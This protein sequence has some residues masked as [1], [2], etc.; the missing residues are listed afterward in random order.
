DAAPAGGLPGKP[1][2]L[3]DIGSILFAAKQR[4]AAKP[5]AAIP[6]PTS[7]PTPGPRVAGPVPPTQSPL[8]LAPPPRNWQSNWGKRFPSPPPSPRSDDMQDL[9]TAMRNPSG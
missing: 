2:G 9:V 7:T 3:G 5:P 8:P 6:S 1:Q 4:A